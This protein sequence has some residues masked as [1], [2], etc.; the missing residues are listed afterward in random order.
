[1]WKQYL[2]PTKS[3]KAKFKEPDNVRDRIQSLSSALVGLKEEIKIETSATAQNIERLEKQ[4]FGTLHS[5]VFTLKKAFTDLADA[6]LEDVEGVRNDYRAEITELKQ[7]IDQ[8]VD[9]LGDA[10][11]NSSENCGKINSSLTQSIKQAFQ[12]IQNLKTQQDLIQTDVQS[13][14]TQLQETINHQKEVSSRTEAIIEKNLKDL[15]KVWED[16]SLFKSKISDAENIPKQIYYIIEKEKEKNKIIEDKLK[17]QINDLDQHI[18]IL[19]KDL[20]SVFNRKE[21]QDIKN[22]YGTLEYQSKESLEELRHDIMQMNLDYQR[23]LEEF[24]VSQESFNEYI[25][26]EIKSIESMDDIVNKIDFVEQLLTTQR[27]EIFNTITNV[28][29]NFFK[30]QEKIVKAIYQL[31]RHQEI[32]EALLMV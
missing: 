13:L 11:K 3:A 24:Q 20:E 14:K 10:T 5:Q 8:K 9:N 27:R 29:Q 30:K 17:K 23:K 1:M 12:H 26:A 28:E 31:A 19:S 4:Q 18:K 21:I 22:S 25:T 7:E 6:M 15:S 32:P 16:L 2:Q